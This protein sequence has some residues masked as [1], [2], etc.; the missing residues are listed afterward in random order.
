MEMGEGG[1]RSRQVSGLFDWGVKDWR[2]L[3]ALFSCG[4]GATAGAAK[5]VAANVANRP[6]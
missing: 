4:A 2:A 5:G 3:S 1:P 6:Q